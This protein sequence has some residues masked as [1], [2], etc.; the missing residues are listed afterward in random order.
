[1]EHLASGSALKK[2]IAIVALRRSIPPDMYQDVIT[3]VVKSDSD[4]EVR[5][6]AIEQARTLRDFAPAVVQAIAQAAGDSNRPV[7]ERK[8]AT[9]MTH[10]IGL[11]S[12]AP[13][14]T[15]VLSSASG[16]EY[17]RESVALGGGVFTN[18]LLQGLAG[19]A[20]VSRDGNIRFLDLSNFVT[21]QV[22]QATNGAQTP[23]YASA[24]ASQPNPVIF[25][26]TATYSKIVAVVVGNSQYRAPTLE[27]K[28][29][30]SDAKRFADFLKAKGAIVH[31]VLDATRVQ[32]LQALDAAR[33]DADTDSLELFYYSG[34]A[35]SN[36]EGDSWLLPTDAKIDSIDDLRLTGISTEELKAIFAKPSARAQIL[37]LE[38]AFG[39]QL[40]GSR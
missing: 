28:Y 30:A 5:K 33:A 7:E 29:G 25:G 11:R 6:T 15:F 9:D 31:L 39:G 40:I 17:T 32:T 21:Q 13:S 27:L 8:I 38:G 12:M 20:D 34:H 37:F 14:S 4:P 18:Y 36:V 22:K 19:K 24:D 35:V 26:P 16:A 23:F 2:Q 1:M 10:L 3:I